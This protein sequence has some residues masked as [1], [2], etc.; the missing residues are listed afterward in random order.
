M[1]PRLGKAIMAVA[2]SSYEIRGGTAR[3]KRASSLRVEEHG[4]EPQ[5]HTRSRNRRG[6]LKFAARADLV[7]CFFLIPIGALIGSHWGIKPI[8]T[9]LVGLTAVF[10][11]ACVHAVRNLG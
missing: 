5:Q 9:S 7:I 11:M 10:V 6:P 4:N 2:A 8:A 1:R 3:I